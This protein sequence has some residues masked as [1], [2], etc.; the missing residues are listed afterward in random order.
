MLKIAVIYYSRTGNT[1]KMAEFVAEGAQD[2]GGQVKLLKAD[3]TE[4]NDLFNSDGIIVGSPTYYGHSAGPVR[5]LFDKSVKCHGKLAGKVGGAFASSH[6]L[7]GGNET[8][9]MDILESM[10]VHGMII[11]GCA[12][13]DHYGPVALGSPDRRAETQCRQ[14][15]ER[16]VKLLNQLKKS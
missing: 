7:A 14:L 10:L 3:E 11:Q 15:G 6:N 5:S 2:A 4:P 13:G 1:Q 9:L 16:I 12:E 8:T